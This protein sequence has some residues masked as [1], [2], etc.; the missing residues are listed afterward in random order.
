M[1]MLKTVANTNENYEVKVIT[2]D[3]KRQDV[4][5]NYLKQVN[6][7]TGYILSL[8][9][10]EAEQ[11]LLNGQPVLFHKFHIFNPIAKRFDAVSTLADRKAL[12]TI[13]TS[14]INKIIF[15]SK[16]AMLKTDEKNKFKKYVL[17]DYAVINTNDTNI[18]YEEFKQMSNVKTIEIDLLDG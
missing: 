8:K 3:D 15:L 13:L 16:D 5:N 12:E 1:L 17:Y 18:D 11:S 9:R 14:Y 2:K 10:Y 7:K 4:S 6:G